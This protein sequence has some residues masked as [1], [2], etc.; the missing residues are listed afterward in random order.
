[1]LQLADILIAQWRARAQVQVAATP[2]RLATP[3]G[4]TRLTPRGADRITKAK[5]TSNEGTGD[6]ETRRSMKPVRSVCAGV[7]ICDMR[8]IDQK[9][10]V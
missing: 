1:L 9:L 7:S 5:D 4:Q 8:D 6:L 2:R 10:R 3:Q